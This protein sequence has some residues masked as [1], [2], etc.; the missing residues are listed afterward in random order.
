ML[1]EFTSSS[2][3]YWSC[4]VALIL[5]GGA[6]DA[7][8]TL[9]SLV[10]H[11]LPS[12]GGP[13]KVCYF[14]RSLLDPDAYKLSIL[15][16]FPP[17][18]Q[19]AMLRIDTAPVS[20]STTTISR[21]VLRAEQADRS[22]Q[23]LLQ[24]EQA[25]EEVA[26]FETRRGKLF[27]LVVRIR[28][29]AFWSAALRMEPFAAAAAHSHTYVVPRAKQFG[30]VNDRLGISS[31]RVAA[32][33]NRRVTAMQQHPAARALADAVVGQKQGPAM[34]N[35]EQLLN[36]TL[37]VHN[38]RTLR[39]PRLP[40]CLLVKRKCKCCLLVETCARSGNK[41][42]PCLAEEETAQR[43]NA[44]LEVEPKWPPNAMTRYDA[45]VPSTYATLRERIVRRGASGPDCIA[46]M[47]QL[48]RQSL[49][50][51]QLDARE[52]CRLAH[53]RNCTFD[54]QAGRWDG[55]GCTRSV[56]AV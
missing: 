2:T 37:H 1:K 35:S 12:L 27:D 55:L 23:E 24:L 18:V 48:A 5:S 19:L 13:N 53:A 33:V 9:P 3:S 42:R 22:A 47:T 54:D 45:V 43:R 49:N 39:L 38:I 56:A 34:L 14:V 26:A 10:Q 30:G 4:P 28:L 29:D 32:L 36:W 44:S 31:S 15:L 40:F 21:A 16:A 46:D 50:P 7:H 8:M 25:Q 41:C 52:V 51:S 6:R 20:A 11:V 17:P